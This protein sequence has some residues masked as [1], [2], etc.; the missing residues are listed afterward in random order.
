MNKKELLD[1]IDKIDD[2]DL[3][4]IGEVKCE[5]S[6]GNKVKTTIKEIEINHSQGVPKEI[7]NYVR[8]EK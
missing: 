8:G 2:K 3:I 6:N 7:F 1:F 4:F 5:F